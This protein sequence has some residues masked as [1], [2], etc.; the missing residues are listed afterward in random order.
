M[1]KPLSGTLIDTHCHVDAYPEPASILAS[2]GVEIIAVTNSPD[3]YNR[4][5]TLLPRSG[6]AQPAL[7]LHP[8]HAGQLGMAGVL[9]FSRMAAKA[10]WIGEIGLDFSPAG[11]G[12]RPAQLAVFEALLA[13]PQLCDRP[14]TVHTRGA[15]REAVRRLASAGTRA[16]LHWYTGPPAVA[17]DALAAGL[18]FSVNPAMAAS[19]KAAPCSAASPMTACCSKPTGP[20]R[21]W[22]AAGPPRRPGGHVTARRAVRARPRSLERLPRRGQRPAGP[23]ASQRRRHHPRPER[24]DTPR[25]PRLQAQLGPARRHGRG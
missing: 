8:L 24:P 7:G 2:V 13:L 23:Q 4:L 12:S 9:R 19:A 22:R 18:S 11:R 21:G 1:E 5:A 6:P 14:V 10:A 17:D 15:E 25:G 3:A 16:V 20:S